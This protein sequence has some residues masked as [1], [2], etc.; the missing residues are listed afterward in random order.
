MKS[1]KSIIMLN[2]AIISLMLLA[3]M[4]MAVDI[5]GVPGA[6]G[7][8]LRVSGWFGI[9]QQVVGWV[10]RAFFVVAA[11]FIIIAA[12]YYLTAQGNPEKVGEAKNMIIYAV[13]AI[14]VAL[15]AVGMDVMIRTFLSTGGQQ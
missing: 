12:F 4:A 13:V 8:T 2:I 7:S 15:I 3:N 6:P 9:L 14:V 11:L 10:Y 1:N 5:P